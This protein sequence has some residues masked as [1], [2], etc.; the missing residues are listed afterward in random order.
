MAPVVTG[1]S[2]IRPAPGKQINKKKQA[3]SVRT[4]PTAGASNQRGPTTWSRR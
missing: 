1:L 2:A 3:T 4:G